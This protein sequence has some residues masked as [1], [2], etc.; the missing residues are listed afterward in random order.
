MIGI[1]TNILVRFLV[2]DDDEQFA[3][4]QKLIRREANKD[5]PVFISHLI[6]L[7]A[8]WVLSRRYKLKKAEILAA[9]SDLLSA[10]E[11]RFEDEASIEEALYIWKDSSAQFGDCLIGAH[12]RA[13]K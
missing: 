5:D 4:A 3:R 8:E 12:N 13:C 10:V 2:Q 9:F 6:L 1:D 7:E 11:L